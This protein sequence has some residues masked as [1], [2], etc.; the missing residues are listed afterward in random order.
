MYREGHQNCYQM[1]EQEQKQA[2]ATQLISAQLRRF[3]QQLETK[4]RALLD[5]EVKVKKTE[6]TQ[7]KF[8]SSIVKDHSHKFQA[9]IRQSVWKDF[10]TDKAKDVE[11]LEKYRNQ[12]EILKKEVEFLKACNE[13]RAKVDIL[14]LSVQLKVVSR[15]N[16]VQTQNMRKW[17]E[18]VICI[19]D[20]LYKYCTENQL[21]IPVTLYNTLILFF[22]EKYCVTLY[23]Y[24][25]KLFLSPEGR[26]RTANIMSLDSIQQG[27]DYHKFI[28]IVIQVW[29]EYKTITEIFEIVWTD[30]KRR[31]AEEDI[32]ELVSRAQEL[33]KENQKLESVIGKVINWF[34]Y[35]MSL[36]TRLSINCDNFTHMFIRCIVQEMSFSDEELKN[37]FAPFSPIIQN[38]ECT[39]NT[40]SLGVVV[41][42]LNRDM[43]TT[44]AGNPFIR[45]GAQTTVGR[46]L[47]RL[48]ICTLLLIIKLTVRSTIDCIS[49]L[50]GPEQ[51]N[52]SK[53]ATKMPFSSS[54]VKKLSKSLACIGEETSKILKIKRKEQAK[55]RKDK[56]EKL[57]I[58]DNKNIYP[59]MKEKT[60]WHNTV[61]EWT[62]VSSCN[63]ESEVLEAIIIKITQK[64]E[65][66]RQD[67]RKVQRTMFPQAVFSCVNIWRFGIPGAG[68]CSST[69]G[70]NGSFG[71]T[72][73]A[74]L[75]APL[76]SSTSWGNIE[77]SLSQI[78][79]GIYSTYY[80]PKTY[81]EAQGLLILD[82][83]IHG[84]WA[85]NTKE[86]GVVGINVSK[87]CGI[88]RGRAEWITNQRLWSR[89]V[90]HKNQSIAKKLGDL[91]SNLQN[92]CPPGSNIGN[93]FLK[94]DVRELNL[95]DFTP[96]R[97][98]EVPTWTSLRVILKNFYHD[99]RPRFF[100]IMDCKPVTDFGHSYGRKLVDRS[101][102][103]NVSSEHFDMG[104][105]IHNFN[106][107]E[108]SMSLK[109]SQEVLGELEKMSD[110]FNTGKQSIENLIKF[111]APTSHET[112]ENAITEYDGDIS[113]NS[114]LELDSDSESPSFSRERTPENKDDDLE[115]E[116]DSLHM[117]ID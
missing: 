103:L 18:D 6:E 49:R 41:L 13:K 24:C 3:C 21:C 34:F 77:H 86:C 62:G 61:N 5:Y 81:L 72:M 85:S 14:E 44:T 101:R 55:V 53:F 80:N 12:N 7:K 83:V 90:K 74:A 113:L 32:V 110:A 70:A 4:S 69:L 43:D 45:I 27:N 57:L 54:A 11:M 36:K 19:L 63:I 26:S 114:S 2:L 68:Y 50:S 112:I 104:K 22:H 78:S 106:D 76:L 28:D 75:T 98:Y 87:L 94:V 58:S 25:H 47:E 71:K 108:T 17:R 84:V 95:I 107:N 1:K 97:D 117:A 20:N 46:V 51:R 82:E 35:G 9:K 65:Q 48:L 38:L 100:H 40:N 99:T 88:L 66:L 39:S 42:D 56:E 93:C 10:E 15:L 31:L 91:V 30:Y 59:G 16:N 111:N 89:E 109:L 60:Y 102:I 92:A 67:M 52:T 96:E 64:P 23:G 116:G 79:Y 37:T 8:I 33:A 105:F 29:V 115:M 73:F